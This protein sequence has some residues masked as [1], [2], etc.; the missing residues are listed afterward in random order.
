M[1]AKAVF[2][3]ADRLSVALHAAKMTAT[4]GLEAVRV[5]HAQISRFRSDAIFYKFMAESVKAKNCL[6]LDNLTTPRLHKPPRKIDEGSQ[7][8]VMNVTAI[9]FRQYYRVFGAS[10]HE[11]RWSS[12]IHPSGG[13]TAEGP[14]SDY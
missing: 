7:L 12:R 11:E 4:E 6:Y 2:E 10:V 3:P 1:V 8:A 5:I 9:D 13:F 14:V